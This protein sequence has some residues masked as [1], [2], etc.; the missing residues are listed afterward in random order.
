MQ[1]LEV[2]QLARQWKKKYFA[3]KFILFERP[4]SLMWSPFSLKDSS[5]TNAFFRATA[6]KREVR[7][8]FVF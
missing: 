7:K 4:K 5:K 3:M 1:T 2:T 6:I 8:G